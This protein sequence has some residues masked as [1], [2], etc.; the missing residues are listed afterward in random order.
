LETVVAEVSGLLVVDK[1]KSLAHGV[2][3][4]ISKK[5]IKDI[6]MS[7]KKSIKAKVNAMKP[8]II[9]VFDG[10]SADE[11]LSISEIVTALDINLSAFRRSILL[12]ALYELTEKNVLCHDGY[13]KPPA[14]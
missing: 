7:K 10:K 3:G 6:V 4:D 8:S 9:H 12:A 11:R 1:R 2:Q 13:Y 5:S 14:N